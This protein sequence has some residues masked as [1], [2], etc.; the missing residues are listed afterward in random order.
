MLKIG[1]T[2][3]IRD[4]NEC[5]WTN[6]IKLNVL[7]LTEMLRDSGKYDVYLL[8]IITLDNYENKPSHLKQLNI[9]NLFAVYEQMDLIIVMGGEMETHHVKQFRSNHPTKKIIAYKCG[10]NYFNCVENLL[11]GKNEGDVNR[12]YTVFDEIWYI[13]QQHESN[14]GFLKT[15]HRSNALIVPFIWNP[16]YLQETLEEI[17]DPAKKFKYPSKYIPSETK[18]IGIMEPNLSV[19]KCCVIPTMIA[20]E[21]FRTLIGQKHIKQLMITNSTGENNNVSKHKE[22][23]SI[24]KSFDLFKAGKIT[25]EARYITSF[26]LSQYTDIIISHQIMN[27]LNYVYLDIAYMGYPILHN[28]PYVKDLGYYYEGFDVQQGAEKLNDILENHDKRIDEYN[29]KNKIVI[30]RYLSTNPEIIETYHK[31]ISN[32]VTTGNYNLKYNG[33]TNLYD[34]LSYNSNKLYHLDSDRKK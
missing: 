7:I 25:A 30:N 14:Q 10:N 12:E 23:L 26:L 33:E 9:F 8:N 24:I 13:P 5:F 11:F 18:V 27:P 4:I 19:Q 2:I 3:A 1:V 31:L 6:G 20:E 32:V 21:S 15:L 29:E 22:F 16:K 17:D 34:N 28:A